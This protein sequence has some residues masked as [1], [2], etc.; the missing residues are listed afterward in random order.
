MVGVVCCICHEDLFRR[1]KSGT[2]AN[3]G[4]DR[5]KGKS[6]QEKPIVTTKCGH[7]FHSN[8]LKCWFQK[9]GA[10]GEEPHFGSHSVIVS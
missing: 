1:G 4:V 10:E 2:G 6:Q 5:D 9:K 7:L 3:D 8:C